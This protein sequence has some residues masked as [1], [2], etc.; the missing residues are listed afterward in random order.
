MRP[1]T[2]TLPPEVFALVAA[3]EKKS[4][5]C[6]RNPKRDKWLTRWKFQAAKINGVVFSITRTEKTEKEWILYL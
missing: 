4:L 3:G 5:R 1:L 2:I 6:L